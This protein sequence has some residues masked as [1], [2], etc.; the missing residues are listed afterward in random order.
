MHMQTRC[1]LFSPCPAMALSACT[2]TPP[3]TA[4][5]RPK[6][7]VLV[8]IDGLPMRQVT[9]YRDQLAPDGFRR[10]LDRG[11]WFFKTTWAPLLQGYDCPEIATSSPPRREEATPASGPSPACA[12]SRSVPD[13]QSWQIANINGNRLPA[14]IGDRMDGPG[15]RP[16][17]SLLA[18]PFGDELTLAFARAAVRGEK[19]GQR[20]LQDIVAVSLSSHDYVNHAFGPEPRL[21]HDHLL[22]LDRH[23]DR[24]LQAFFRFLDQEVGV[25][26]AFYWTTSSPPHAAFNSPTC[27]P[28]PARNF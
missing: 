8:V 21:S 7:L 6:L 16:Y 14:V 24:H 2:A 17:S 18:T 27:K 3:A 12:Y 5:Q 13:G 9:G 28:P 26:P 22:H 15:P 25:P 11:R 10:F 23:L 4:P 1:S 19:L 20:G